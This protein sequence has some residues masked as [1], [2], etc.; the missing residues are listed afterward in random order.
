MTNVDFYILDAQTQ[1][2]RQHFVCLLAQKA[3]TQG[4]KVYIHNDTLNDCKSMDEALWEYRDE[5]F[6]P[7]RLHGLLNNQEKNVSL[8]KKSNSD[9][10]TKVHHNNK[11]EYKYLNRTPIHIGH[12]LESNHSF[13]VLIN[14]SH[15]VPGFIDQFDRVAEIVCQ[16]P[17]WLSLKRQHYRQYK[18]L[19]YSVNQHDLRKQR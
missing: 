11:G 1:N 16:Q 19:G 15:Q 18:D 3:Y 10:V 6:I 5:S 12:Q 7:H 14:L 4:H 13:E 8:I 17:E 2:A 9:R